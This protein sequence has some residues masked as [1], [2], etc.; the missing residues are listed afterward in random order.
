MLVEGGAAFG[1]GDAQRG[2]SEKA[3]FREG[4][5]KR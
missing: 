3:A 2:R 4:A 1:K 5:R